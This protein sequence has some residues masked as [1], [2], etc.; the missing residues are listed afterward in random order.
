MMTDSPAVFCAV[1]N[2][3]N[4]SL[5]NCDQRRR[6]PMR[7]TFPHARTAR[8]K[9]K[10]MN[11]ILEEIKA[12][13]HLEDKEWAAAAHADAYEPEKWCS[14]LRRQI[15][16]ADRA[17]CSL[18]TDEITGSEEQSLIIGYRERLISIAAVALAATESLDR[19]MERRRRSSDTEGDLAKRSKGRAKRKLNK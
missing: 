14:L 12:E 16:L 5:C 13:R 19:T 11:N 10:H 7:Y 4:R 17:A 8:G 1:L 9:T 3:N 6:C 2:T 15:R 18:A